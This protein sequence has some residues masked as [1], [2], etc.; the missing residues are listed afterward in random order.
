MK[1]S[2][3]ER[4]GLWDGGG[5]RARKRAPHVVFLFA[6][7]L[8]ALSPAPA[9]G[10]YAQPPQRGESS[11]RPPDTLRDIQI[12][13]R[14]GGQLPL[15]AR[16]RDEAGREVALGDYFGRKPI[17]VAPVYYDCPM[18]C[19][20]VL[21]GLVSAVRGQALNVGADFEVVAVSFDPREGPEKAANKKQV[22]LGDLRRKDDPVAAA[23][24][25]L[26]TGEKAEIDSVMDA[27]GFRYAFD[28]PTNQFAHAAGV[29]V[30][31]PEGK[32]S[33]YFYGIEYAPRDLKL[34]LVESSSGKIGS[35]VDKLILYCYHYDPTTGKY[36]P[37]IMNMMRV[38]GVVTL[39]GLVA[40]IL[41][42]RRARPARPA[43]AGAGGAA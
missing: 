9:A 40:L 18:L 36:G 31:T 12:E 19:N 14:Q 7:S 42:L 2:Q 41:L 10:Q 21:N 37:V 39:A 13:Q 22:I 23:G 33:H 32:I 4:K 8:F 43:P 6:L 15:G 17:I 5:G 3:R 11:A 34:A 27:L 26:L 35:A 25:H 30:A 38:A 20:Q 28:A 1:L 24:L 16:F 29:M